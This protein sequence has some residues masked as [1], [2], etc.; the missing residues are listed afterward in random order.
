[1]EFTIS[2]V[3]QRITMMDARIDAFEERVQMILAEAWPVDLSA[4]SEKLK[5]FKADLTTSLAAHII[6][7]EPTHIDEPLFD[8]FDS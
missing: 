2:T 8:L 1:M 5:K 6:V 7:L 3:E 4:F